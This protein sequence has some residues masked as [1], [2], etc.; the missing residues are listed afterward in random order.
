MKGVS[1]AYH[2]SWLP[3]GAPTSLSVVIHSGRSKSRFKIQKRRDSA[4]ARAPSYNFSL[5]CHDSS[6]MHETR[7]RYI[8][9]YTTSRTRARD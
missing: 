3:R 2:R 7:L 8:Y 6:T 4:A 1:D 5:F 9:D